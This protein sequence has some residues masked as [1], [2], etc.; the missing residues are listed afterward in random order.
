MPY[1]I[2]M[3]IVR[4]K[5]PHEIIRFETSAG[6]WFAYLKGGVRI[7]G[8]GKC[9]RLLVSGNKKPNGYAFNSMVDRNFVPV[10]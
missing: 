5:F 3:E 9:D 10:Y 8:N 6:R 1:P 7:S 4:K 2:F